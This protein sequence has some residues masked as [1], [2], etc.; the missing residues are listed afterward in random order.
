MD[1]VLHFAQ[2]SPRFLPIHTILLGLLSTDYYL[3]SMGIL[4][5]G[6]VLSNLVI[7]L[8]FKKL[9][10]FMGVKTLPILG[11]GERPI[12][13]YIPD[14]VGYLDKYSGE[15]KLFGMPSGHSQSAW[16]FY[17]FGMLYLFDKTSQTQQTQSNWVIITLLLMTAIAIFISYSRVYKN[18]HTTQQVILGGIIGFGIGVGGY[19]LTKYIIDGRLSIKKLKEMVKII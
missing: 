10:S 6:N 12:N 9:Y 4:S 17:A 16:F 11:L 19:I 13:D 3:I 15:A 2:D 7:K 14:K 18:Y 1:F 5:I 8:L